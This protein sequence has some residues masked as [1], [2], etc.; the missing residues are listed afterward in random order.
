[1]MV[2]SYILAA[3]AYLFPK[4]ILESTIRKS[5]PTRQSEIKFYS[6]FSGRVALFRLASSVPVAEKRVL[7]P[8]YLCNVVYKAFVSAGYNVQYYDVDEYFEPHVSS[9]KDLYFRH[10][11]TVLVLAPLYG[12]D[13]GV[14]WFVSDEGQRWRRT[15]NVHLVLD[16]CQDFSRVKRLS[17][18]PGTDI[19]IVTSYNDK[20]FPGV[21]GSG[22][23]TDV[24]LAKLPKPTLSDSFRVLT[25]AFHKI[26]PR[27]ILKKRL[28]PHEVTSTDFSAKYEFSR[29]VSFPYDFDHFSATKAQLALGFVGV[30]LLSFWNKRRNK[31]IISQHIVPVMFE[32]SRTSPFV[33]SRVTHPGLHR[34]KQPYALPYDLGSSIR[35]NLVIRHNKGFQ[36][37]GENE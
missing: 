5:Y 26:A 37:K 23:W 1:M 13:G 33:V 12:A 19:S 24:D 17:N 35:P 2:L 10:Q 7:L 9:I 30:L 29:C 34:R 22:V 18:L 20:S 25:T 15:S 4:Q 28:R 36:D 21:M 8:R 3:F 14:S 32:Y 31:A 16:L 6:F 27:R 11:F